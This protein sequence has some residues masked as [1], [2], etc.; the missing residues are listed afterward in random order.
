LLIAA[1]KPF[2]LNIL[3]GLVG[4]AVAATAIMLLWPQRAD[5]QAQPAEAPRVA[6]PQRPRAAQPA[7]DEIFRSLAQYAT[8]AGDAEPEPVAAASEPTAPWQAQVNNLIDTLPPQDAVKQMAALLPSLPP[9]AC[10]E[11]AWRIDSMVFEEDYDVVGQLLR[12]PSTPPAAWQVLFEGL[13]RR[14]DSIRLPLLADLATSHPL[15]EAARAELRTFFGWNEN[16][17]PP[18]WPAAVAQHLADSKQENPDE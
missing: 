16:F 17:F 2:F 11:T 7:G 3:A 10:E 4:G 14:P 6:P 15:G 9:E 5:D 18:A 13:I 1:L 8:M 12:S